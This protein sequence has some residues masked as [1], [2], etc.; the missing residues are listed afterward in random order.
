METQ[1]PL[2]KRGPKFSAHVYCG[3]TAGW[4][5]MPLGTKVGLSPGDS[6]LD[7]D[8]VPLPTKGV[9]PPPQFLVYFHCGQMAGCIKMP[10]GTKVGL[11][12]RNI[13]FD[14]DPAIAR[15]KGTPTPTQFWPMSIVA[16]WL[17]G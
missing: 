13:V 10:L 12:Q 4:I 6:V 1:L 11:G 14:V 2:R 8:A 7:G 9:E 15:R 5:K 17:D 16:K 3:Q